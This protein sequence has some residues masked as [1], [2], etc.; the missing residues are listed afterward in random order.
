MSRTTISTPSLA[1]TSQTREEVVRWLEQMSTEDKRQMSP[2][3]LAL[4][5][6]SPSDPWIHGFIMTLTSEAKPVGRCGFT[7]P[8]GSDGVVEIA[9]GV[10]PECEGKGYATEAARGL[11][12]FALADPRVRVVRAHTLPEENASTHVLTKCGFQRHGESI[13]R[14]AGVVWKWERR[15]EEA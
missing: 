13:D 15:K 4:V 8:P 12:S 2:E 5:E 9:Y 7:G 1:L 6:S 11:V 10:D 3:W 14:E